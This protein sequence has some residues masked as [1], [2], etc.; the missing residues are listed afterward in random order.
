MNLFKWISGIVGI[1]EVWVFFTFLVLLLSLVG[2]IFWKM[3]V[4]DFGEHE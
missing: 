1:S 3:D 2:F 4:D